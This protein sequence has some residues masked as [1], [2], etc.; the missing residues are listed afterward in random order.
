MRR[1]LAA[2]LVLMGGL[3][4][5]ALPAH[6]QTNTDGPGGSCHQ[7]TSLCEMPTNGA[8]GAGGGVVWQA[9]SLALR[10]HLSLGVWRWIPANNDLSTAR[11]APNVLIPRRQSSRLGGWSKP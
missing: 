10:Q 7:V 2:A 8:S 4:L 3:A 1:T 6:S 9:M 5:A 11:V